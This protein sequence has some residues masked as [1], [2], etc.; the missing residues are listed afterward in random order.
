MIEKRSGCPI[1]WAAMLGAVIK[2]DDD[3][4]RQTPDPDNL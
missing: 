4:V 3:A 1:N 2:L